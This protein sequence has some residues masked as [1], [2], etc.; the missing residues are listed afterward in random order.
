MQLSLEK[1]NRQV[2]AFAA[3]GEVIYYYHCPFCLDYHL[4]SRPPSEE[5]NSKLKQAVIENFNRSNV[6]KYKNKRR[7]KK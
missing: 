4:T 2:D 1:A 7:W 5:F 6:E 3:K